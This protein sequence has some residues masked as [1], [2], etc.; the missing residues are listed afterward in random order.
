[1]NTN[2]KIS[3]VMTVF[4][5]ESHLREAIDSILNQTFRDFEFI[6]VD[7]DSTDK[8]GEIICSYRDPRIVY[9][10]NTKNVGQ[11]KALN[12]GI[13]RS[14]GDFI[15]RM[16]ADDISYPERLEKQYQY[17]LSHD[18]IAVVGA[19]YLAIDEEGKTI[20]RFRLPTDPFEIRC[21]L[22]GVS[23]LSYQCVPHPIVLIR[24]KALFDVGLYNEEIITQDYDLWV[25]MSRKYF[26][27]NLKE[28]LFKYRVRKNAQTQKSKG[29][30]RQDCAKMIMDNIK[31]Y[32]PQLSDE[33]SKILWRMLNFWPQA[34]KG[35]SA[36]IFGLFGAFFDKVMNSHV[37][38]SRMNK[39]KNRMKMYYIPQLFLSSRAFAIRTAIKIISSQPSL[40]WDVKMYAKIVKT[41]LHR[42]DAAVCLS[43]ERSANPCS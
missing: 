17:L 9:V 42:R 3:V 26:F 23:E 6:I 4:N 10:K 29:I 7:N 14:R 38:D 28:I 27:S 39:I 35:D 33:E 20:L 1:V 8:T 25:R 40:L 11:S 16:D 43:V 22:I 24:K 12:I 15:A 30:F 13:R 19:Q 36:L 18:S 34:S 37:I 21:Y 2:P 31:Y 41:Y 32:W 5:G